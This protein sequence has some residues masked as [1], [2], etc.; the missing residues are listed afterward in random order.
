MLSA[1]RCPVANPEALRARREMEAI[2]QDHWMQGPQRA[3]LMQAQAEIGWQMP[4]AR[5]KPLVQRG[6]ALI[7]SADIYPPAVARLT[8]LLVTAAARIGDTT[9]I[10]ASRR[11]ILDRDAGRQLHSYTVALETVDACAAFARGDMRTAAVELARSRPATFH[12]RMDAPL[13]MLEAEARAA[14][15]ERPT[16]DSLYRDVA[17][18]ASVWQPLARRA[19]QRGT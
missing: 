8:E 14:L 6:L 4:T 3:V 15:G 10:F 16:A 9:A 2:V 13:E 5:T 11:M 1:F 7:E 18:T 19:L 12:G 17:A